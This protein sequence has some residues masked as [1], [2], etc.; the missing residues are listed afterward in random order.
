MADSVTLFDPAL[1]A[2]FHYRESFVTEIEE[3]A[4]L[5]AIAD[6]TFSDFEMRGGVARRRVAFFGQ[7]YDRTVAGPLPHS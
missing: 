1:P 2:G 6:I 3:Q 4:L 5:G 7:S